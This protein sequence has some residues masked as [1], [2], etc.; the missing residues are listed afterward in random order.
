MPL[1]FIINIYKCTFERIRII[2]YVRMLIDPFHC[3]VYN[4]NKLDIHSSVLAKKEYKKMYKSNN[5]GVI[6]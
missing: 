6:I 4:F 1:G 2:K 5:F 3:S